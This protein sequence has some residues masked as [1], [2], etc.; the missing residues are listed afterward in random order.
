MGVVKLW[1]H[2]PRIICN[3]TYLCDVFFN[4]LWPS[5]KMFYLKYMMREKPFLTCSY[6]CLRFIHWHIFYF[7]SYFIFCRCQSSFKITSRRYEMAKWLPIIY[8]SH[9]SIQG[10]VNFCLAILGG[11]SRNTIN[12][13]KNNGVVEDYFCWQIFLRELFYFKSC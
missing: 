9:N 5:S 12:V 7:K 11:I 6:H 13:N 2:S 3:K 4:I 1:C 10:T 8:C